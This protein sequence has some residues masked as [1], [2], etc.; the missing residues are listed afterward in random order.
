MANAATNA[1]DSVEAAAALTVPPIQVR[2]GN[3]KFILPTSTSGGVF[4][5]YIV[6]RL[7]SKASNVLNVNQPEPYW[8]QNTAVR[9]D[10][11]TN[12]SIVASPGDVVRIFGRGFTV[13]G[14]PATS[15]SSVRVQ[16][17]AT[18]APPSCT[19]R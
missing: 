5:V 16:F 19:C 18:G 15:N 9:M 13:P 2:S 3:L 8:M 6:N 7:T 10:T 1:D 14:A 12:T 4:K 17:S 11:P